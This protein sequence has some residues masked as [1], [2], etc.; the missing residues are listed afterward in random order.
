MNGDE[1]MDISSTSWDDKKIVAYLNAGISHDIESP[2]EIVFI[3][4]NVENYESL[5]N[6]VLPGIKVVIL[7]S[8]S[9]GF[10][11]VTRVIQKYP[12]ISSIHIVRTYA[13][14]L[15][16]VPKIIIFKIWLLYIVLL[17]KS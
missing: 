8:S 9:D 13:V 6:G 12:Q 14:T 11:Q 7:D 4:S 3:D 10:G 17:R 15:Y 1:Y 16:I 2:Q 5:A